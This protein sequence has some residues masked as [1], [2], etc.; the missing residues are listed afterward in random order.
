M[1]QEEHVASVDNLSY[2]LSYLQ[3]WTSGSSFMKME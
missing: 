1:L 2:Y 3:F